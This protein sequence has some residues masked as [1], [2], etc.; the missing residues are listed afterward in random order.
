MENN[1]LYV[2]VYFSFMCLVFP[3]MDLKKLLLGSSQF[4]IGL[5]VGDFLIKAFK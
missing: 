5:I 2:C 3:K 1:A 4:Y